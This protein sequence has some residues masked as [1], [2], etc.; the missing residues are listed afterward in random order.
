MELDRR[1]FVAG[2]AGLAATAAASIAATQATVVRADDAAAAELP[3]GITLEDVQNSRVELDPVTDFAEEAT[4]DI[5]VVGAG[6][7]GV[8]AVKTAVEEG[9]S[10]ACLQ[11]QETVMAN[12][13]SALGVI[14]GLSTPAGIKRWMTQ[15]A[16]KNVRRV[17]WELFEYYVDHSEETMSWLYQRGLEAGGEMRVLAANESIRYEDGEM[18]ASFKFTTKG[19]QDFITHLADKAAEEGATFYWSTPAVQLVQDADGTVS[20]VIGK[21]EDGTYVKLNAVKG[22]ILAAGDYMNNPSLVDTYSPD[23]RQFWKKQTDRT[24]DGHILGTLAGGRIAPGNHPRMAHGLIPGFTITPLLA[25]DATGERF[26]NEDLVMSDFNTAM[27]YRYHE[28]DGMNYIYRFFDSKV[29]EK[30][31]DH[32]VVKLENIDKSVDEDSATNRYFRA[33]TLEGLCEQMELPVETAVASIER[34]NELCAAGSDEDFG[35]PADKMHAIDTPPFYCLR[36]FPG[37]SALTGGVLVDKNYQVIDADRKPI[38]HLFAA[39]MQAGDLCGGINW[40]MPGGA[41]NG[42]CF[43]AGRYT[44]I[45]ALTGSFEPKNPCSF[46]QIADDWKNNEGKFV[47]ETDTCPTEINVW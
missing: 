31:T 28:S 4:Y 12:G 3:A 1:S 37:I 32:T 43:N 8:V 10:V 41:S 11:K 42:H 23:A 2:T 18:E 34:Y 13:S 35:V 38:P 17:N 19:N 6:C 39:G 21:R 46:E 22:V 44:V 20:G 16:D 7:A 24:G 27:A 47:W 29:N 40:H 25:L 26:M 5:V 36:D 33:D 14:K 45:Y 9:A 15:W 30:Y